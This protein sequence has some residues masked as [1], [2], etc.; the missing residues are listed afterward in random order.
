M[1]IIHVFRGAV[2]GV[3]RHVCDQVQGQ[4]AAGHDI[5]IICDSLTGG[6]AAAEKLSSLRPICAL[7]IERI[8]ISNAPGISDFRGLAHTAALATRLKADILHGHGAK[9]G[10]FARLAA[11]KLGLASVYTPHG[12]S[13][14]YERRSLK[15]ALFLGTEKLLRVK[16]SGLAFVCEFERN[17]FAQKIGIGACPTAVIY[18]GLGR[19]DFKPRQLS[20]NATDLL[21]VGEMRSIKGVD[22][23]LNALALIDAGQRPSLTLVGDGP[24]EAEFV[25]LAQS[26]G[27]SSHVT[28][29]GRKPMSEA[30]RLGRILVVPSLRESF[31]YVVIEAM[32]AGIR[33]I[34]ADVGGISEALPAN[35]L[36]PAGNIGALAEKLHAAI[37]SNPK[38]ATETEKLRSIAA[39]RF[40]TTR[41]VAD[42]LAFYKRLI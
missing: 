36:F 34:A 5:G 26:L 8:A 1:R 9:G 33:I 29:V 13:L 19:Q 4:A 35:C 18:N 20:D 15:G 10:L 7:G 2:G 39:E 16:G 27:L 42:T 12:G 28:F 14:H 40:S 38:H 32:A 30:M 3:L 25:A 24:Q 37:A 41:M 17:V 21:F 23:L 31:P 6:E 11:R 22:V